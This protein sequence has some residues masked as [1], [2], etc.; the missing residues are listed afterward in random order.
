MWCADICSNSTIGND[1]FIGAFSSINQGAIIEKNVKIYPNC[2]IG[3]NV[4][5]KEG[6][7]LFP[8]VKIY[9][10]CIILQ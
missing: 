4:R 3:E 5:I 10:N 7:I 9:H 2:Y 1:V 8:G 6:S